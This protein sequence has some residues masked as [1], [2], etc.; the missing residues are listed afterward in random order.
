MSNPNSNDGLSIKNI[1]IFLLIA[2][3]VLIALNAAGL[4]PPI[5]I[6]PDPPPPPP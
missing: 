5:N 4:L 2:L 3:I 6:Y 1:C